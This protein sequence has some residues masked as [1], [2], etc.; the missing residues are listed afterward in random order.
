MPLVK[1]GH[2][3]LVGEED[4][5]VRSY[6][7]TLL[8]CQGYSVEIAQD[9][10]EVLSYLRS[11]SVSISAVLLDVMMP[12]KNG[13]EVLREIRAFDRDTP[14]ILV[15][16]V[17]PFNAAEAMNNGASG[18]IEKPI[19]PEDLQSALKMVLD[20]GHLATPKANV[21]TSMAQ[22]THIF[23]GASPQMRK[24][25]RLIDQIGWSDAPLLIQGETGVGK[26][27]L[28]REVHAHS[29]RARKSLLKLNCAALPSELVESELF[30]YE[31]GAFTGAFQRKPGM[32]ELADGGTLMLDE[33]GDMDYRLQAKLLQVLQDQEFQRLGG[34]DTVRVD[35]RI[36]AASH[37]DL[38]TAI[39]ENAFRADLYYRL[40][41]INVCVP[42]LRER[43][44]DIIPIAEFLI[45]KHSASGAPAVRLPPRLADVF[46]SYHWPGNVRELENTIRKFLI[47][48]DEESV[49][50][51]L[52]RKVSRTLIA[53]SGSAQNTAAR[54][55]A[56]HPMIVSPET[57]LANPQRAGASTVSLPVL[58]QLARANQ[59]A[60]RTAI[61]AALKTTRWNRRQAAILLHI[62][63]KALLYKMRVLSI[64]KEKPA[65]D[66][67]RD[68]GT[69]MRKAA[70]VAISVGV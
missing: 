15:S 19:R 66:Q 41:V 18:F 25:Q 27:V 39:A 37:R 12:R 9:G 42:P 61:L 4:L 22:R 20:A 64:K 31:R 16:D 54:S 43:K 70:V 69:P 35:V 68:Q 10:D 1:N 33:I 44:E 58:K 50:Q 21:P 32:F 67:L 23:F 8:K 59:E 34:R 47:F 6:L 65:S 56:H 55:E 36:I 3:V 51:E 60:Q 63:Y 29:P 26:E 62:E 53:A 2:T 11:G 13:T 5:E 17:S 49:E 57:Q 24:L 46:L 48:L 38:E 28:A 7:E 30:G 45:R 14:V 52:R 40:N